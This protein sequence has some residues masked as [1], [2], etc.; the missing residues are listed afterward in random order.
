MTALVSAT[1]DKEFAETALTRI[2]ETMDAIGSEIL[3]HAMTPNDECVLTV[4]VKHSNGDKE[5][6]IVWRD[7]D[8]HWMEKR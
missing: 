5:I 6:I 4:D 8:V 2:H 7:G 3:S 1:A